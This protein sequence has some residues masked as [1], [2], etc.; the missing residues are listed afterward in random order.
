[1]TNI[2]AYQSDLDGIL[3]ALDALAEFAPAGDT[4][5]AREGRERFERAAGDIRTTV[6]CM[7][8]DYIPKELA[9]LV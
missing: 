9:E 4:K 6:G 7:R 5:K 8:N 3:K 1:M 2:D